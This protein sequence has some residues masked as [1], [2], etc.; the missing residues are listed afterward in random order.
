MICACRSAPP[1]APLFHIFH[2][3]CQIHPQIYFRPGSLHS[4]IISRANK[5]ENIDFQS[6]G[7]MRR[8]KTATLCAFKVINGHTPWH[9]QHAKTAILSRASPRPRPPAHKNSVIL[10]LSKQDV[11]LADQQHLNL[12]ASPNLSLSHCMLIVSN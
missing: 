8:M 1:K 2:P 3:L 11:E 7:I 6:S 4:T 12:A 5:G 9:R 10:G